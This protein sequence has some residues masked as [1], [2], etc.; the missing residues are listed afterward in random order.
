MD[1]G[2]HLW[3]SRLD[4]IEEAFE[5]LDSYFPYAYCKVF[6]WTSLVIWLELFPYSNTDLITSSTFPHFPHCTFLS[7]KALR[8]IPPT[9]IS[10]VDQVYSLAENIFH[11]ALHQELSSTLVFRDIFAEQYSSSQAKKI[12]VPWRQQYWE[13][14]LHLSCGLCLR[15]SIEVTARCFVV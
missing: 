5:F 10:S 13:P 14:D 2:F 1:I 7:D 11:E 15:Q 6:D 8:H 12:K 4:L 9:S 3:G